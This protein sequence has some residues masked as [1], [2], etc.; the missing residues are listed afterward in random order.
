MKKKNKLIFF[1]I[2]FGTVFSLGFYARSIEITEI[3]NDLKN[4]AEEVIEED[5][6]TVED[7]PPSENPS[8]NELV[9]NKSNEEN[10]Q[11]ENTKDEPNNPEDED[12]EE[13]QD[14]YSE[15]L[16][17][18]I[19]EHEESLEKDPEG[20]KI[21]TNV[22]D[23]LVL[24]NKEFNLPSDFTPPDLVEPNIPFIVDEGERRYMREEA[25]RSLEDLFS[26][27]EKEQIGII[28]VSGY[29]SYETQRRIFNNYVEQ[30]GEE[31]A[32]K[33]S[34]RPGQS[35]HQTGLAMD[36]SS[37]SVDF[38]LRQSFGETKEGQWLIENAP[39]FGF[40]I[41]Y[42]EG[43]EHITGYI[44]EPWHLRYVGEEHAQKISEKGVTLEQYLEQH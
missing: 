2:L 26:C 35:E 22:L 11:N 27:A 19:E 34:A 12:T 28:G 10:N 43:K 42:P 39:D 31:E 15:E 40:I 33:F 1:M 30:N 36:V 14:N 4:E 16:A 3:F 18:H 24:V 41:R 17:E 21:V 23:K 9:N 5:E 32:N 20:E 44:Y 25:A 7:N 8:D 13:E 37:A 6:N 38:G 29:R